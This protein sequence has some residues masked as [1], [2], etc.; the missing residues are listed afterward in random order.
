MTRTGNS[1]THSS[2][3]ISLPDDVLPNRHPRR[4]GAS[5]RAL[6]LKTEP[7]TYLKMRLTTEADHIAWF[8]ANSD[9]QF[10]ARAGEGWY[11]VPHRPR[12]AN[13]S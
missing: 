8:V 2:R 5:W 7:R 1:V 13:T 11:C 10:V 6:A 3:P 9:F 12:G 4:T